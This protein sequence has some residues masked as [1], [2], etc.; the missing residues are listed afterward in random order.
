MPPTLPLSPLPTLVRASAFTL[1]PPSILMAMLPRLNLGFIRDT[2]LLSRLSLA[3]MQEIQ[4]S[5][6]SRNARKFSPS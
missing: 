1:Q 3:E 5:S 4:D 2:R 6:S